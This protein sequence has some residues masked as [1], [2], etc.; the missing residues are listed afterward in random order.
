[1]C[2]ARSV[3]ANPSAIYIHNAIFDTEIP[4]F[5]WETKGL[6]GGVSSL[7]DEGRNYWGGGEIYLKNFR[8]DPKRFG[9]VILLIES[10]LLVTPKW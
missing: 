3:F 1:M 6:E 5:H 8:F 9:G 7:G 2:P 4:D 10:K